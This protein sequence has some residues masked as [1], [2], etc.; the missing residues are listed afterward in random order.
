LFFSTSQSRRPAPISPQLHPS[1]EG[2][3]YF[4]N[5]AGLGTTLLPAWHYFDANTVTS[6]DRANGVHLDSDSA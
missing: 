3:L 2:D 5:G 1:K 4:E 6:A